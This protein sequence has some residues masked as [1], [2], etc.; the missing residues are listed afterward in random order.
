MDDIRHLSGVLKSQVSLYTELAEL[1]AAEKQAIVKWAINDT[2]AI[3]RQKEALLKRERIQEEAR[4]ALL[5]KISTVHNM[6][7]VKIYDVIRLAKEG[8]ARL[9]EELQ[10]LAERITELVSQIY[11]ENVSLRMLYST[12]SKLIN[13]FFLATGMADGSTNANGYGSP[14][15]TQVSMLKNIVG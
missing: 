11:A 13:D 10:S 7:D 3:A 6:P 9:G 1:M 15:A 14:T 12:N 5:S 2:V 4:N 8:D